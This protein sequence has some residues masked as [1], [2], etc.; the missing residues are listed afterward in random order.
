MLQVSITKVIADGQNCRVSFNL[1]P[2]GNYVAGG[3]IVDFTKAV[4]D[5]AFFGTVPYIPSDQGP[6]DFD[7]WDAGGNI[8]N[9][10]FPVAGSTQSNNKVKFTSAFNTELAAGAYPAAITGTKLQG[11]AVFNKNI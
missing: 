11:E 7:V 4:Q 5:P 3:D 9:G 6:I 2:S 8:A 10:V 1:I